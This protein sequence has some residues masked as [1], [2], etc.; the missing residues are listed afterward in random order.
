MQQSWQTDIENWKNPISWITLSNRIHKLDVHRA[1]SYF[2]PIH[3]T[4]CAE[5]RT[6]SLKNF[7]HVIIRYMSEE[8][9]YKISMKYLEAYHSYHRK[10]W[11]AKFGVPPCTNGTK[12]VSIENCSQKQNRNDFKMALKDLTWPLATYYGLVWPLMVLHDLMW[13]FMVFSG[14]S[15][16][17]YGLFMVFY[18]KYWF[19][20]TTWIVFSRDHRSKFIWSCCYLSYFLFHKHFRYFCHVCCSTKNFC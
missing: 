7:L 19:D 4:S 1:Q 13:H 5:L 11:P 8:F 9:P 14:I 17:F 15:M 18:G 2:E 10:T 6:K 12:N 20:C 16:V 3:L